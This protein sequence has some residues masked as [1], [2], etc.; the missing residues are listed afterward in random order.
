MQAKFEWPEPQSFRSAY[1]CRFLPREGQSRFSNVII[2][3]WLNLIDI[4]RTTVF[5]FSWLLV[6]AIFTVIYYVLPAGS[7]LNSSDG[8]YV[9]YGRSILSTAVAYAFLSAFLVGSLTAGG[10]LDLEKQ[11]RSFLY[12]EAPPVPPT[13]TDSGRQVLSGL[14]PESAV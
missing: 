1:A 8:Q 11:A 6:L 9:D 4:S 14:Y 10:C 3:P 12:D 2:S 5:V 13:L 7:T